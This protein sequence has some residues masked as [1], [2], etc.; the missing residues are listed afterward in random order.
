MLKG[1]LAKLLE[2]LRLW[3]PADKAVVHH[4]EVQGAE[5][6]ISCNA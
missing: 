4:T 5:S 6:K 3:H 2:K 1:A